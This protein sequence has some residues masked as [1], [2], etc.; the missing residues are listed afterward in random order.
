M[1]SN[2]QFWNLF[3]NGF[4][5][6]VYLMRSHTHM[7]PKMS[8]RD[9]LLSMLV[10]IARDL[11]SRWVHCIIHSSRLCWNMQTMCL[12]SSM[13]LNL[14]FLAMRA[15]SLTFFIVLLILSKIAE[16]IKLFLVYM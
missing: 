11:S 14:G 10:R 13:I 5:H 4:H 9:T 7:Y 12:D 16:A 6:S 1:S 2:V 3:I 8:Q 15:F